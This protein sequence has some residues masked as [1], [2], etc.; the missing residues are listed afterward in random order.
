VMRPADAVETAECWE[1]AL[2]QKTRPTVLALSRQNLLA[3]RT[4]ASTENKCARGAYVL[5]EAEG[6]AQVTL[7]AT[8]SEIEIAMKAR[9]LLTAQ[10][11]A[12]RVVSMPCLELFDEQTEDYRQTVLGP[13]TVKVAIEA[14]G[15]MGW[16]RYVG[17]DGGFVGMPGFGASAPY[18]DLY[19]HF[20]ITAEHAAK[21]ALGRLKRKGE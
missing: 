19:K 8:G 10:K 20:D 12:A 6:N 3:V 13:G 16:E 17:P 7:L 1:I 4:E 21:T 5:N 18:K 9:Y 11:V 2:L 14:A 15:S